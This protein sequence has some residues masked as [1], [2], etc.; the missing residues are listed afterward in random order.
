MKRRTLL[1]QAALAGFGVS[2]G[3]GQAGATADQVRATELAFAASMA[4][5]DH[6]AFTALL[7]DQAVFFGDESGKNVLRGK[8]A[9]SAAW[10]RFFEAKDAPFSWEP[11]TVEVLGSGD[12]A[13]S[14][15]P[16]RDPQGTVTGRFTSIWRKEKAGWRIVFD[17]GS[18][19][20]RAV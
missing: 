17:K 7:S 15:G 9:V 20:C 18:S 12:L 16:V 4:K 1:Q 19:V 11:D 8:A 2:M 13:L 14:S 10:K 3:A 6:A 5:R